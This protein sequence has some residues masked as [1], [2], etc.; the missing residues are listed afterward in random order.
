MKINTSINIEYTKYCCCDGVVIL[1]EFG[2]KR[3]MIR[4]DIE[5]GKRRLKANK[6]A[7]K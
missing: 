7:N 2:W 4:D 5:T 6:K 3:E 1:V